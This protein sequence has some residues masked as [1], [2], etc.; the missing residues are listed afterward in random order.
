MP[1]NHALT[2]GLRLIEAVKFI[3]KVFE[4]IPSEYRDEFADIEKLPTKDVSQNKKKIQVSLK[5]A[6]CASEV[7]TKVLKVWKET[8]QRELPTGV[9]KG[10]PPTVLPGC[11][12]ITQFFEMEAGADPSEMLKWM[13]DEK[14][15]LMST[16]T[17][18]GEIVS[19]PDIG[20]CSPD[21]ARILSIP[22]KVWFVF[23]A[24]TE[25][26]I[27]DV[28]SFLQKHKYLEKEPYRHVDFPNVELQQL[29]LAQLAA[30]S[31]S[32][33]VS[34]KSG[35]CSQTSR[36]RAAAL[37]ARGG[38]RQP[39]LQLWQHC[40]A[41]LAGAQSGSV[42]WASWGSVWQCVVKE[43]HVHLQT[44]G[45]PDLLSGKTSEHKPPAS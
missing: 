14:R 38:R 35:M 7:F 29:G 1:E 40:S 16:F 9:K 5:L 36:T 10:D 28:E 2:Y 13:L 39:A 43:W 20:Y 26:L 30:S 32:L 21:E 37:R 34:S 31:I 4:V 33:T 3:R 44:S 15:H 27:Q 24:P 19:E 6:K 18:N 11:I 23:R 45:P 8:E 42:S 41:G 22:N 17:F 25:Q 12:K